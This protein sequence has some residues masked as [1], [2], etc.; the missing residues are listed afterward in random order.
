MT[1]RNG[2]RVLAGLVSW[3]YGCAKRGYPGV[4]TSLPS[5]FQWISSIVTTQ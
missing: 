5:L 3:G 4:Y 1:L 2:K